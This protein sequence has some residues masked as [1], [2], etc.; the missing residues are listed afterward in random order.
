VNKTVREHPIGKI[1]ER[2][3][4]YERKTPAGTYDGKGIEWAYRKYLNGKDGRFLSKKNSKGQ[5]KPIRCCE[6]DPQDGYDVIST[7][8][9]HTRSHHVMLY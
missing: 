5:W 6:V 7:I 3:I 1:A 2:T 9:V 4:G 8:D